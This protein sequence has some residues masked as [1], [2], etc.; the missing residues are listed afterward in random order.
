MLGALMRG[1]PTPEDPRDWGQ[2][3]WDLLVVRLTVIALVTI[4]LGVLSRRTL[5]KFWHEL[6]YGPSTLGGHPHPRNT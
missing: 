5:A 6:R 3:R 2:S 4:A 1:M